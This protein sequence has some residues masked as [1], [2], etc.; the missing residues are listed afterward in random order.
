MTIRTVLLTA[1]AMIAFAETPLLC[2]IAFGSKSIDAASLSSLGDLATGLCDG[3]IAI[4][5]RA[6]MS[7]FGRF[8]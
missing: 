8:C 1:I 7:G 4:G 2:R 5:A 6:W 3:Q